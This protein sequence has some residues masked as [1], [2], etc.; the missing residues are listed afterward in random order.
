[1][2]NIIRNQLVDKKNIDRNSINLPNKANDDNYIDKQ[3]IN[4]DKIVFKTKKA[5]LVITCCNLVYCKAEMEYT[6]LFLLNGEKHLISKRL[7]EVEKLLSSKCFFRIHYSYIANLNYVNRV[8][9]NK[10][11]KIVLSNKE[12]LPVSRRKKAELYKAISL[13]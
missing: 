5:D 8:D 3:I 10:S 1:M 12:C 13:L 7:N 11:C 9:K 6:L 4:S 2:K